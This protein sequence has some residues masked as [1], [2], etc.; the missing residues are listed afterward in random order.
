MVNERLMAI[1]EA[2]RQLDDTSAKR[3]AQAR[4]GQNPAALNRTWWTAAV[5]EE[6]RDGR[7]SDTQTRA[8]TLFAEAQL[9]HLRGSP[10]WP[11]ARTALADALLA[12]QA[13][14]VVTDLVVCTLRQAWDA[15]TLKV[16]MAPRIP[17]PL[18]RLAPERGPGSSAAS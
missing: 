7:M 1:L 17:D 18:A 8:M 2:A 6:Q 5:A 12:E 14:G 16:A 11:A 15:G 13:R 10:H 4:A 3:M 9:S